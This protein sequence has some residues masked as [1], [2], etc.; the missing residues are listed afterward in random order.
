MSENI[1]YARRIREMLRYEFPNRANLQ[2][3]AAF[4]AE[5]QSLYQE[6][7]REILEKIQ[8]SRHLR[9]L[10]IRHPETL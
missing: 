1:S 9:E 6:Y 8:Y 5:L 7:K 3:D 2:T 10:N 4:Y